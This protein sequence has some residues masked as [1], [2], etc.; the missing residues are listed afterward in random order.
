MNA[1]ESRQKIIENFIHAYNSFDIEGMCRDL[2]P[3]IGFEHI[4]NGEINLNT[5]GIIAFKKQAEEAKMYFTKREQKIAA[6]NF[7]GDTIEVSIAYKGILAR[8]LPN[9]LQAGDT[10]QL[11]G[12]SIYTFKEDKIIRIQDIS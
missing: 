6:I 11:Q 3:D 7:D 1:K 9:G 8:D 10:L 2:H 12:K 5:K 4:V